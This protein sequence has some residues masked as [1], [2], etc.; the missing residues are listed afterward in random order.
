MKITT[1]KGQEFDANWM[2]V[3]GAMKDHLMIEIADSGD[4]ASIAK[5]FDGVEF[6]E[7][8]NEKTPKVSERYVGF[9]RLMGISRENADGVIRI[10]LLA[11]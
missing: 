6:I 7:K 3:S 5:A 2:W 8:V 10:T 11:P 4:L 1:N 9:T